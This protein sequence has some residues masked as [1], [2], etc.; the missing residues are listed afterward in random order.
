MTLYKFIAD[1]N[2]SQAYWD[3][4]SFWYGDVV[5]NSPDANVLIPTI[6]LV[7]F[8]TTY[9]SYIT[10]NSAETY[11]INALNIGYNT[12]NIDTGSQL[13]VGHDIS[14]LSGGD[15]EVGGT[16]AATTIVNDGAIEGGGSV[17]VTGTLANNDVLFAVVVTAQTLTNTGSIGDGITLNVGNGGLTNLSN[18]TLTGGT[19]TDGYYNVG[20]LV[21]IDAANIGVGTQNSMEMFD[22]GLGTYVSILSTLQIIAPSGELDFFGGSSSSYEYYNINNLS[23]SGTLL[24]T[25]STLLATQLTVEPGGE[26]TAGNSAISAAIVDNGLIYI[27][28]SNVG[29]ASVDLAGSVSGAGVLELAVGYPPA[30]GFLVPSAVK[31]T[32]ELGGPTT[33]LVRFDNGI[34]TLQLDDAATFTGKIEPGGAGDQIVLAGVSLGSV[35]SYS[36][37]GTSAGGTLTI[38]DGGPPVAL[39][40]IG[41]FDTAS[42]TLAAG[43]QTPSASTPNLVITIGPSPTQA[44]LATAFT[45]V[46]RGAPDSPFAT[47]PTITL[48][49]GSTVPNPMYLDAQAL[50]TLASRV[51]SGQLTLAQAMSTIEHNG[52]TTTSVATIAYQFFTGATPNSGGYDYL[53]NSTA[54]PND[55]N[56]AYYAKF[57][58]QNRYINFAVNLGKF[59]AG[60]MAFDTAYGSL[61]LSDAMTKAYTEIFGFAP[62]VDKIASILDAIVGSNGE[63]RADYFAIYGGDGA[64]GLGTKAAAVG[65]LMTVAVQADLGVYAAATDD[66]LS[67]LANG[68]AHYNVDL[69]TTYP[70]MTAAQAAAME[71][72]GVPNITHPLVIADDG[73]S[74]AANIDALQALAAG[75]ELTSLT[76]TD[77][78]APTLTISGAQFAADNQALAKI[79]EAHS[80]DVTAVT[81]ANAGA[82]QANSEVIS[83]TVSDTAADISAGLDAL[84]ADSKL[85]SITVSDANPLSIAAAQLLTDAHALSALTGPYALVVTGTAAQFNGATITHFTAPGSE[86][87]ITDFFPNGDIPTFVENVPGTAAQLSLTDGVHSVTV[88]LIGQLGPGAD[89]AAPEYFSIT[90]DGSGGT[91]ITWLQTPPSA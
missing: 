52:D 67:A 61:D 33:S 84:Q 25:N 59:G 80:L 36:Y 90:G 74:V 54:N 62:A 46:L 83:F 7:G 42:F 29:S 79:I 41:D 24:L 1:P 82:I 17:D 63:T 81:T 28:P 57:N 23:I 53:I 38:D 71:A 49:D 58:A 87:H 44:A 31:A 13:S 21:T 65:W 88:T 89:S 51:D 85:T 37:S 60:A 91:D 77:A 27:G 76:L 66:F 45:N 12:L 18:G 19:Y 39:N 9:S 75:H 68:N 20:G 5:P 26:I 6:G 4:A 11:S 55:L 48:A 2:N 56:D 10:I 34:G 32:L 16:L 47:S 3:Q 22:T 30:P 72:F 8:D 64:D 86:L 40:F 50:P 43:V 14:V 15:I 69:L 35:T 70:A 78:S 73:A